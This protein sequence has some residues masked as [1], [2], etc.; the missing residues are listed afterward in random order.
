MSLNGICSLNSNTWGAVGVL[1]RDTC[2][3]LEDPP[4]ADWN[5]WDGKTLQGKDGKLSVIVFV[6]IGIKTSWSLPSTSSPDKCRAAF[7]N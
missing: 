6:A 3:G 2:N 1:P 5:Y 4:D 7:S